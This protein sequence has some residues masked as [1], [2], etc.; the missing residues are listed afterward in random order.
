MCRTDGAQNAFASRPSPHGL[1]YVVSRLRRVGFV[2]VDLESFGGNP[3][4]IIGNSSLRTSDSELQ[5]S[6][7]LSKAAIGT[8]QLVAR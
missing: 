7:S 5:Q 3:P 2:E 1:G 4:L 6:A 8:L